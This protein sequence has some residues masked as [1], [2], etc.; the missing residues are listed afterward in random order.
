MERK[1]KIITVLFQLVVVAGFVIMAA[2]SSS[3]DYESIARGTGQGLYCQSEGYSY[4]G[5]YS[6]SDCKAA[7]ARKGYSSYCTGENTVWCGCK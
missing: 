4:I 7:C 2:G 1:R 3:S 6:A 5:N